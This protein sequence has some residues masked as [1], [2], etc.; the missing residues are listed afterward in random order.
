MANTILRTFVSRFRQ[1]GGWKVVKAYAKKDEL[2]DSEIATAIYYIS[3]VLVEDGVFDFTYNLDYESGLTPSS[4]NNQYIE[5]SN[6]W[7][8]GDVT[9]VTDGKYRYWQRSKGNQLRIGYDNHSTLTFSVP[10]SNVITQ[11][12]FDAGPFHLT[13]DV[14]TLTDKTWEGK[15]NTV[16]FTATELTELNKI[17]VS[18]GTGTAE[19]SDPQLSIEDVYLYGDTAPLELSSRSNGEITFSYD[20][21]NVIEINYNEELNQYI[22]TCCEGVDEGSTKVTAVQE[23]TDTY[24]G[25]SVDFNVTVDKISFWSLT[26][27][28]NLTPDDVFVIV[29][30]IGT[31]EDVNDE[32]ASEVS[33]AMSNDKGTSYAPK[34]VEVT[35]SDDKMKLT[36][37]VRNNMKWTIEKTDEDSYIFHPQ[38][39]QELSLYTFNN[40]DGMRVGGGDSDNSYILEDNY[41][42]NNSKKRYVGIYHS[43]EWRCY[44]IKDEP[45]NIANQTI[46]FYKLFKPEDIE[47]TFAQRAEGYSTLFYG[48]KNL[49]IP[50][51]VK[52][53]TYKVDEHGK[54]V[55]TAYENVIPKGSAVIVELENKSLLAE[56]NYKASFATTTASETPHSDNMLYGFDEDG[57]ETVGPDESKEYLFYSLSLNKNQEA[58]S[59][60]FYWYQADGSE[61]SM[62]AHRAYL[63][64][65]KTEATQNVSVFSFDG[66]GTGI[67]GIVANSLPADGIYTLMGVR[68]NSDHLHKGIYIVNGKKLIIK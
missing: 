52:A 63:A 38:G 6:T 16:V 26:D 36:S 14:G 54:A 33:Y 21:E 10:E 19:S 46:A 20:P 62:P 45:S 44:K 47:V 25:S 41:L 43:Q 7:I 12:E 53:Y 27:L 31:N 67:N 30:T 28:D 9:L 39:N 59:I 57:Q 29:G 34:A 35:V 18:S 24:N 4:N 65:E 58:G 56:Q 11:I 42:Y 17:I 48:E 60:G 37:T 1:F 51:G 22:V 49:V 55:E 15:S 40:N 64:V 2:V 68:V 23:P 61:F 5:G 32:D 66:M 3:D 50:E 8:S 13:P